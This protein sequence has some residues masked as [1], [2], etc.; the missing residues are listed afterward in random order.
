SSSDALLVARGDGR[1]AGAARAADPDA[2]RGAL[3]EQPGSRGSAAHDEVRAPRSGGGARI[4]QRSHSA[5]IARGG[6][7]GPREGAR[8]AGQPAGRNR[9]GE[10]AALWHALPGNVDA[11]G[12]GPAEALTHARTSDPSPTPLGSAA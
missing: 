7:A 9:H 12:G 4:V 11:Q 8:E 10:G 5:G 2:A 6:G 3:P 1:A